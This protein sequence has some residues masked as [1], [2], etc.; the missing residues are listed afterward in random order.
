MLRNVVLG[1]YEA[2]PYDGS[3]AFLVWRA[4]CHQHGSRDRLPSIKRSVLG[5]MISELL[6]C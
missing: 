5:P 3:G 1:V 2:N 6:G 4:Y